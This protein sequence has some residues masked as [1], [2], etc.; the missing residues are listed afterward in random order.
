MATSVFEKGCQRRVDC[1]FWSYRFVSVWLTVM[2]WRPQRGAVAWVFQ[3]GPARTGGGRVCRQCPV[4]LGGG[5]G[6]C[7]S[8]GAESMQFDRI[9][10]DGPTV[11]MS[12]VAHARYC[13]LCVRMQGT[14]AIASMGYIHVVSACCNHY[15]IDCISPQLSFVMVENTRPVLKVLA[16]RNNRV[17]NTARSSDRC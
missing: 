2:R 1:C 17:F 5:L 10:I 16:F 7:F 3:H 13:R 11:F 8:W 14:A 9:M 15:F 6:R 12:Q 4:G